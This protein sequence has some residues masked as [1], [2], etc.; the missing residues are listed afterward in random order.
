MTVAEKV[1]SALTWAKGN[2]GTGAAKASDELISVERV[3]E[4]GAKLHSSLVGEEIASGHAFQKH[5]IDQKE[6]PGIT[7]REQF[8]RL[9][10]DVVQNGQK[11]ELT[12]GKTYYWKDGTL[13]IRNPRAI[14]GG[15]AY[16]PVEGMQDFLLG[17][18]K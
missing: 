12:N 3:S 2:L 9:I 4:T 5:V 10:E 15:T 1:K 11:R 13:V 16:R 18:I 14:D 8:A 6:F 7:T 17:R